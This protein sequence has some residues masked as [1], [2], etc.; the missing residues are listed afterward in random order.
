[1]R[2][3]MRDSVIERH[4][5]VSQFTVSIL[6]SIIAVVMRV[7]PLSENYRGVKSGSII[8]RGK[9]LLNIAVCT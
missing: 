6:Q 4:Q 1:M 9:D 8:Y 3:V 7:I 5:M 2:R